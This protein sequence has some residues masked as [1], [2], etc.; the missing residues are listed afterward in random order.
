M[1]VVDQESLARW[2]LAQRRG[3]LPHSAHP[4][5]SEDVRN[6][7]LAGLPLATIGTRI[8]GAEPDGPDCPPWWPEE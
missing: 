5:D 6:L 4:G 1:G 8:L 2:L 3:V 7:V